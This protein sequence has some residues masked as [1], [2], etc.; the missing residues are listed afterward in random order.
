MDIGRYVKELN[1]EIPADRMIYLPTIKRSL[2][3]N[4]GPTPPLDIASMATQMMLEEGTIMI[5]EIGE[6][7]YRTV[8]FPFRKLMENRNNQSVRLIINSPGGN[9]PDAMQLCA[10]IRQSPI[11]VIAEV[12]VACSAAFLIASQCHVRVGYHSSVMMWHHNSLQTG[13]GNKKEFA[14]AA[15]EL[16]SFDALGAK[17]IAQRSNLREE[18]LTNLSGDEWFTPEEAVRAGILD[19]IVDS[20]YVVPPQS[21][22]LLGVSG[23]AETNG[24]TNRAS[25]PTTIKKKKPAKKK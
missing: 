21:S 5:N 20:K 10:M 2:N 22:L 11:P 9:T 3:N 4:P 23:F 19:F 15:K 18:F 6:E 16:E 13:S 1:K 25:T 7:F 8:S 17:M 14:N 12:V 24:N